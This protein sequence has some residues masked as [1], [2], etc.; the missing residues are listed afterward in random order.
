[1]AGHRVKNVVVLGST[2]SVGTSTLEVVRSL[3]GRLRV[4]GLSAGS[5]W[6]KL[7]RQVRE[8]RPRAAAL[9]NETHRARL[10]HALGDTATE[11]LFGPDGPCR[12][13]AMPEA[14]VVVSAIMGWAGFASAAKALECGRVLA[15]AN[16]ESLVVGGRILMDA[17][18]RHGGTILPVD[19]EQSAL[20]QALRSG[21]REEVARVLITASGGPFRGI[22]RHQLGSVTPQQA[23]QH[24]T[25]RMGKKITID[26][27]TM[28]NKALEIVETR[29]LFGLEPERIEVLI[30]PQSIVH[31][32]VEFVDGSVVA[33]LGVPDMKLPIQFALTYPERVA[34][35]VQPLDLAHVG[36]LELM[37]ADPEEFPA[38]KLGYEVARKGGTS[39]A[40][41]NAA[42]EVAVESFLGRKIGFNDIVPLVSTVL[43][44]HEVQPRPDIEALEQADRWA[45]E[46]ARRC[47]GSS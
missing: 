16:K 46:E 37:E 15:L 8:F 18:Q 40:V 38:L 43:R 29:W 22:P 14:E 41:L 36:G 3:P 12:L 11:L 34:G 28:M 42:N 45:R 6:E 2:G 19:S 39:G 32:L 17:A 26:S 25:W 1:V 5:Q 35:P 30:H 33:Q 24:P 20:L 7:A 31:S 47:L 27:A 44:R 21:R 9:A 4:V 13:A 10:E 23:L